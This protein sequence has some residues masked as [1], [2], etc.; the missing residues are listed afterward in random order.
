MSD[1]Y[2]DQLKALSRF[3]NP[4]V[5]HV[6]F[7]VE[8]VKAYLDAMH[9][10]REENASVVTTLEVIK[11][12]KDLARGKV[13]QTNLTLF[14]LFKDKSQFEGELLTFLCEQLDS[15]LDVQT[16]LLVSLI[17]DSFDNF[18]GHLEQVKKLSFAKFSS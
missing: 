15:K 17:S 10:I 2:S 7:S 4:T 18:N 8:C 12:L 11:F 13:N 5:F 6:D 16:K 3:D 9:G 1:F 14:I